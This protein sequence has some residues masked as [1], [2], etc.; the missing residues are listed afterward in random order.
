MEEQA[1]GVSKPASFV[2][3]QFAYSPYVVSS[4]ASHDFE[5][6]TNLQHCASECSE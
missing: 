2:H 3:N 6:K 4:G 1:G 5:K